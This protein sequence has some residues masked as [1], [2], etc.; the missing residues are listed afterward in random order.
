MATVK[1]APAMVEDSLRVVDW[2][3]QNGTTDEEIAHQV[4]SDADVAPLLSDIETTAT[5]VRWV[6]KQTGLSQ[7]DFAQRYRIPV[8]PLRDWERGRREPDAAAVAY[9]W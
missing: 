3:R 7:G 4:A 9:C 6:R 5:R 8:G 1:V 2:Q